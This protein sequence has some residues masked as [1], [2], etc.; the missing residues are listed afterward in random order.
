MLTKMHRLHLK[1][2]KKKKKKGQ[3]CWDAELQ[4]KSRRILEG[5]DNYVTYC[6]FKFF[7]NVQFGI[8]ISQHHIP[9]T[10]GGHGSHNKFEN[11][12]LVN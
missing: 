10:A 7:E 6:H 9:G 11:S 8:L 5:H 3:I 4:R 12:E 1:F 2:V